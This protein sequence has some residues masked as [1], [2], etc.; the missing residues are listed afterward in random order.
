MTDQELRTIVNALNGFKEAG[1]LDQ[2]INEY[3]NAWSLREA[4][5]LDAVANTDTDGGEQGEL[6]LESDQN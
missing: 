1:R 6:G 5:E 3:V 2:Q 4:D